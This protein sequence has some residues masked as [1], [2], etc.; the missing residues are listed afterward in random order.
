MFFSKE[1]EDMPAQ[2]LLVVRGQ[3][4]VKLDVLCD[5]AQPA[6]RKMP[7]GYS[8]STPSFQKPHKMNYKQKRLNFARTCP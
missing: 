1:Y 7:A 3:P 4:A 6:K 2:F 8:L 5:N